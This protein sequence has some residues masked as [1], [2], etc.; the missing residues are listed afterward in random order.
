MLSVGSIAIGLSWVL[1]VPDLW[2]VAVAIV[3]GSLTVAGPLSAFLRIPALLRHDD[4]IALTNEGIL[5]VNGQEQ[6]FYPWDLVVE[7]MP[8][9]DNPVDVELIMREGEVCRVPASFDALTPAQLARVINR[10]RTKAL[11]NTL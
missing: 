3:G 8:S 10:V 2:R 5:R 11:W 7:A 6:V 9:Q 4:Y 1:P